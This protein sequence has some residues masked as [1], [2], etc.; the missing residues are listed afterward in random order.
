MHPWDVTVPMLSPVLLSPGDLR[1]PVG[2]NRLAWE[3]GDV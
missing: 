1:T 3:E 2:N